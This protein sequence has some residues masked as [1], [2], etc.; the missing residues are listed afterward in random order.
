MSAV[1]TVVGLVFLDPLLRFAGASDAI[2]PFARSYMRIILFG[3][4]LNSI[5]FGMNNFIRAE[6]NPKMAMG[7]MLIG[8]VLNTILDPIFIFG[9]DMGIAGAAWATI[10]SQGVSAVWVLRYFLGGKS[11]L[12]LDASKM[13]LR[14]DVVLRIFALGSAP[15]SMQLAASALNTILNNRLQTYG[16]DM[17]ISAMGIIYS[18]AMLI[19]MPIF[20]LNQGA[21]PIIGYN[22]GAKRYKRVVRAAELAILGATSIVIVGWLATRLFPRAI[23]SVFSRGNA[24]LMDI[25][26]RA[27]RIFFSMFPFVG[28]QIVGANYFQA[29]GKPRHAM[30]LSLSRQV[31]LLIPLLFILPLFFGLDGVYGASPGSDVLSSV[32]TGTFFFIELR[33][34]RHIPD[35]SSAGTRT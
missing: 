15:F 8:A 19:L 18:V 14:P 9:L 20:G 10:I 16:G 1:L 28:F 35:R 4:V 3:V 7:T 32:L 12:V 11:H 22:Y 24:E 30:F 34:L 25:G 5:G 31:L 23:I 6:G 13:R 17:A 21:Q 33:S 2:L 29:V 27:M 26:T